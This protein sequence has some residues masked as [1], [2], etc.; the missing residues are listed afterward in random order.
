MLSVPWRSK[1]QTP[2]TR[3]DVDPFMTFR[4]QMDRMFDEFFDTLPGRSANGSSSITPPIAIDETEK[5]MVLT[6]ELPGVTEKDVELS[7]TGDVL[8]IKGEKKT[9]KEERNADTYYTERHFGPLR[10][11]CGC[12]S[13]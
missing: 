12:R 3:E 11:R 9:E 2:A 6:A 1:A 5:E 7:L 4:R 10:D 8:T 13:R